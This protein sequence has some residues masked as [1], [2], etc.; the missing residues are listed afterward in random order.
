MRTQPVTPATDMVTLAGGVVIPTEAL[1]LLWH[2]EAEGF[3]FFPD[4]A[5]VRIRPASKLCPADRAAL[6]RWREDLRVLVNYEPPK[7]T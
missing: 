5:V 6:V 7:V 2:L 1:K 3:G 4:G